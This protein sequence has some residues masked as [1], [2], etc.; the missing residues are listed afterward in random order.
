MN[1]IET[2]EELWLNKFKSTESN[3]QTNKKNNFEVPINNEF[4]LYKKASVIN[5]GD[6]EVLLKQLNNLPSCLNDFLK[7]TILENPNGIYL[8]S[9]IQRKNKIEMYKKYSDYFICQWCKKNCRKNCNFEGIKL[10]IFEIN[11]NYCQC[12][13]TNIK[14]VHMMK[15]IHQ[16][17]MIIKKKRQ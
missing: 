12:G 13:T 2:C 17:I 8:L 10:D 1:E 6:I 14:N 16:T 15:K 4:D 9:E 5:E 11:C 3:N 7:S